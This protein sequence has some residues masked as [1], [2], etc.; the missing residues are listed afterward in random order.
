MKYFALVDCNNFYASCERAFNP[1]LKNRPIVVLSNNDGCII[2]RSQEA[3]DLGVGMGTPY[4]EVK[5]LIRKYNIHVFSSNYPLYGDMSNRVMNILNDYNDEVEVYSIDEAF[6]RLSFYK[7]S[8]IDLLEYAKMIR[9][10]VLRCTGIPVSVGI[11]KTKTLAKLANHIAKRQTTDGVFFLEANDERLKSLSVSKVWGVGRQYQKRLAG[12]G[13]QNIADLCAMPEAWM[14]KEFGVVGLRLLKELKGE[15]CHQLEPP[16]TARKNTMVSRSF[17]RDVYLLSE[18]KEAISVYTSRLGE[19][20]RQYKQL[21]SVITV[22]LWANPFRNERSDGRRY[23]SKSRVLALSTSNSNELILAAME[24]LGELYEEGT[25]YKKI[26]ILASELKP[27]NSIQTNLFV[28]AEKRI[29]LSTLMET[30]DKVNKQLGSDKV[31]FASCGK[32]QPWARKEQWRS[33]RY[34]TNWRELLVV[35]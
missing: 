24:L 4:W 10:Q 1:R 30:M 33:P 27:A 5:S 7:N 21:T 14:R 35:R 2:A 3:K 17:R 19:K 16:V 22:F 8:E 18:L 15:V 28:P 29:Q 6:L 34:T 23:F 32:D 9:Q 26:G 13:V 11:G 25:N 12:V 31:R 20:L